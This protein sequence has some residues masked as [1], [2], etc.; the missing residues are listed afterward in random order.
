MSWF[1]K[2]MAN[3]GVDK[4]DDYGQQAI[5]REQSAK[6]E[7]ADYDTAWNYIKH[8][9]VSGFADYSNRNLNYRDI[10]FLGQFVGHAADAATQGI[11][12]L[13]QFTGAEGVGNYLNDAAKRGEERLPP[14]SKPELSWNYV[15]DPNGVTSAFGSVV[16]SMLPI[17]AAAY[18]APVGGVTAAAA[19]VGSKVPFIGGFLGQSLPHAIRWGLTG[20]VE[21]AMEAGGAERDMREQGMSNEEARQKA[22]DVFGNNALLLGITN[23]IGG[24]ALPH[25]FKGVTKAAQNG[26]RLAGAGRFA[27][28]TGTEAGINAL[29]EGEQQGIQNSVMGKPYSYNPANWSEDQKEAAEFGVAGTAPFALFG[30]PATIRGMRNSGSDPLRNDSLEQAQAIINQQNQAQAQPIDSEP[31]AQPAMSVQEAQSRMSAPTIS[32]ENSLDG[33]DNRY[34][35]KWES[36]PG[37][38]DLANVQQSVK[39]AFN[40]AIA[41]YGDGVTLTGGAE[42]GYH[43]TGAEGHEGGWKIDVDKASVKDPQKFLQAMARHGFKV[44]DEGDHYDLSGHAK[45]GVGGTVVATPDSFISDGGQSRGT[46]KREGHANA[47][48]I[49]DVFRNAGYSD[50]A[51]AGILG[52]A[53]QEHNFSTDMAEE[54]DVEGIG[55]VGGF[56]MFQWQMDP[57]YGGRGNAFMQWAQENN[58]DPNNATVQA[59]YA[60]I[61]AQQRGLTP[62]R[63]NQ[64]TAEEAADLWTDEWE[65]GK[66][67]NERQ[68][69]A[70]WRDR[71]KNGGSAGSSTDIDIPNTKIDTTAEDRQLADDNKVW[72]ELAQ[73][74][75][76]APFKSQKEL[77]QEAKDAA[78]EA[79]DM[80]EVQRIN[81]AERSG[82]KDE[83]AKIADKALKAKQKEVK[84]KPAPAT[85][86]IKMATPNLIKQVKDL[87]ASG[88]QQGAPINEA[89]VNNAL[90]RGQERELQDLVGI[91]QG[92]INAHGFEDRKAKGKELLDY[93]DNNG[94]DLT[95]SLRAG[96]V[97]G[98]P[99]AI[100][101]GQAVVN[102]ANA[103]P[104]Q[105][106]PVSQPT[107]SKQEQVQ[108]QPA[109]TPVQAQPAP[110]EQLTL[111]DRVNEVRG[112]EPGTP[113][114]NVKVSELASIINGAGSQQQAPSQESKQVEPIV[115]TFKQKAND[116]V[117]Q[118]RNN[119]INSAIQANNKIR[120]LRASMQQGQDANTRLA[121][122]EAQDSIIFGELREVSQGKSKHGKDYGVTET[123]PVETAPADEDYH[124]FFDNKKPGAVR[125]AKKRLEEK[126]NPFG[127]AEG[128]RTVKSI[129]ERWAE[130]DESNQ[131]NTK[132]R[133]YYVHGNKVSKAAYDYYNHMFKNGE[134]AV[135]AESAQKQESTKEQTAP[136]ASAEGNYSEL[137]KS[138][139][140]HWENIAKNA[141]PAMMK[142]YGD[143]AVERAEKEGVKIDEKLAEDAK[144]GNPEA[145]AYV[146]QLVWE[147]SMENFDKLPKVEP[148]SK[149]VDPAKAYDNLKQLYKDITHKKQLGSDWGSYALRK[150]VEQGYALSEDKNAIVSPEGKRYEL[151]GKAIE[152]FRLRQR[153]AED[154]ERANV[155]K[156]G[157]KSAQTSDG[158]MAWIESHPFKYDD[159]LS[160]EKNI[161]RAEKL[162][163]E[164]MDK[165]GSTDQINTPER[166]ELRS[167]IMNE[168]Y[169]KNIDK[170]QKGHEAFLIV[171][172]PASG[173]S[174][175]SDP[176]VEEKGAL[177][178]DSDE[179]KKRLPEFS[180][181]LLA[182]AV[183]NESDNIATALLRLAIA[184]GDNVVMPVVGRTYNGLE[185]KIHKF[186]EAGYTVKL[187]YVDLPMNKAIERVKNRFK[188]EGRLVSPDYLKSVG[189]NPRENYDKLKVTKEVDSYEA[190]NNDVPRGANPLSIESSSQSEDRQDS[191]G[192]GRRGNESRPIHGS[193][194]HGNSTAEAEVTDHSEQG[195]LSATSKP[196][197][198]NK[199]QR[200]RRGREELEAIAK[201]YENGEISQSEA[202]SQVTKIAKE[203]ATVPKEG[204][205]NATFIDGKM[206]QELTDYGDRLIDEAFEANEKSAAS[207]SKFK[208]IS[209]ILSKYEKGEKN[210]IPIE[211]L[212]KQVHSLKTLSKEQMQALDERAAKIA[213][214]NKNSGRIFKDTKTAD[215][216]ML[217]GLGLNDEAFDDI[218]VK[219]VT[220]IDDEID[221]LTKELTRELSKLNANPVFN[222]R[223]YTVGLKLAI[224]L[225]KKGYNNVKKL[226]AELNARFGKD[227]EPWSESIIE[228]VRTWPKGVPFDERQVMVVSQA[229]GARYEDGITS[230]DDVQADMKKKLKKHHAR[231]APMIEASYNGISKFFESRKEGVS[232][233]TDSGRTGDESKRSERTETVPSGTERGAESVS[234]RERGSEGTDRGLETS[235]AE[236]GQEVSENGNPE[237][238]RAGVSGET[239]RQSNA[240]E[241]RADGHVGR[242]SGSESESSPM[243]RGGRQSSR[244]GSSGSSR[245]GGVREETSS[246]L[247]N[248]E[249][250]HIDDMNA[251]FGGTPKVR[252]ARN[253]KAIEV[254]QDLQATKRVPT[255]EEKDAMAAYTG[256]GSFGQQLFQGTYENPKPAKGWEE[257]SEWLRDTLGKED[258]ESA[259]DSI[260]NA[261]YT[262]PVIVKAMWDMAR[263]MGFKNGRVLEPSM[264]VGNFFGLMP[265][266]MEQGSSLFGVEMDNT[267]GGM[268]KM[269]YP[270]ANI[271]IKPYQD[272]HVADGTYD[273]IVGNVPFGDIAPADRRYDKFRPN[274]HDYFFLKGIDELRSGGIMMAITSKGTMDKMNRGV[275]MEL[276]KKAELV[277]AYRFPTGAFGEYAG[278]DVVTDVLI[279]KKR[280][281]PIMDVSGEDWIGTTEHKSDK[282]DYNNH[283]YYTYRV[284]NFFENHPEKVLGTMGFGRSTGKRPG[285][286]VTMNPET[287][288]KQ[289]D[290][291]VKHVAKDAYEEAHY[292]KNLQ[293]VSNNEN[294][295]IGT[296][297]EVDGKLYVATGVDSKPIEAFKEWSLGG[298][299]TSTKTINE[300]LEE[301]KDLVKLRKAYAKLED[302]EKND[303]PDMDKLRK[304]LKAVYDA[305]VAKYCTDKNG[306]PQT[307]TYTDYDENGN[308]VKKK[309]PKLLEDT[310]GLKLFKKADEPNYFS[311]CAL[312]RKDGK[313]AKILTERVMRTSKKDIENPTLQE[314]L[315]IQRNQSMRIDI[316]EIAKMAKKSKEEVISGLREYL[317]KTPNGDYQVKDQYLSGNVRRKLREAQNAYANGDKDMK[318]NIEALQKVMPEDIPYYNISVSFGGT[319]IDLPYYKQFI[320]E[321]V[322][323]NNTDKIDITRDKSGSWRVRFEDSSL[324]G[325]AGATTTYGTPDV[326]FDRLL[327]HALNH[328][329]PTINRTD[330]DGTRYKDE[331]AIE[332][333]VEQMDKIRETFADWVWQEE[334]RK[335]AL[336]HN[337]NEIMNNTARPTY[338]GSFLDM[339]GMMLTKGDKEFNLRKHQIN[340]I[341]RGLVNGSGI[342]AHE[343]GT[344][345]TYT[346]GGLAME[347]RR[348]G[349][350]KKPLILAHNANSQTVANDI[351]AMY[352]GAK[353]LYIAG[354]TKNVKKDLMRVKM[355]DWDVIV[356]PHSKTNLLT[357][358]TETLDAM[359]ADIIAELEDD[360]M[361]A[362]KA[363][364]VD[365]S[366]YDLDDEKDI[367]KIRSQTAKDLVKQR[368]RI[369]EQIRKYAFKASDK[370]AIPFEDLGIDMIIVDESHDYKKPPFSTKMSVKGLQKGVSGASV[371]L[372]FLTQYVQGLNNGKG[373][374]LFTG[375]PITNTITEM[376]H[377]MRYVMPN[378]M[379]EAGVYNFDDWFNAF[380]N[381][382]SNMEYTST[383]EV[384]NVDRLNAFV[385]VA[386]LRRMVGQYMD[387]VFAEDMPEFKPRE[388]ASGKTL[389]DKDL[390]AEERDYLI[391]GRDENAVG[392]P[393]MQTIN[394][395]IPM[396]DA[397]KSILSMFMGYAKDWK[398]A[399]K[400]QRKQIMLESLPQSPLYTESSTHKAAMDARMFNP[401][402]NV[403]GMDSKE[404]R[405][406]KNVV[407]VYKKDKRATQVI[408]MDQGKSDSS[409]QIP[410]D[411]RGYPIAKKDAEGRTIK[412][413]VQTYNLQKGIID[414]LIK[415]GIPEKEIA[416]VTGT[417]SPDKKAEIANAVKH[418]EIRVVIGST[419]TLGTGVNMQDNLKAIH[420]IDAPWMPGDLE[421]RNGRILR[422]G[423]K[424][425]TV[426]EYRYITE[427]LDGR[428]WQVLST[429]KKFIKMFMKA[430]DDLRVLDGDA[431]DVSSEEEASGGDFE[432]TLSKATGDPRFLRKANLEETVKKLEKSRAAFVAGIEDAKF[433]LQKLKEGGLDELKNNVRALTAIQ[434]KY[435]K[436]KQTHADSFE[437][438][439]DG[440]RYTKTT[441]ANEA[442][443]AAFRNSDKIGKEFKLGEYA[444]L[445]LY[446][447]K[448]RNTDFTASYTNRI[449][450][451][452]SDKT[453]PGFDCADSTGG[454]NQK[455]A[456]VGGAIDREQNKLDMAES[457]IKTLEK[458]IKG[459]FPREAVLNAKQK[460]LEA[461]KQDLIDNPVPPPQWLVEGAPMQA[462]VIVDGKRGTVES[463]RVVGE[464]TFEQNEDGEVQQM[465]ATDEEHSSFYVGV[466]L[467]GSDTVRLYPWQKVMDNQGLPMITAPEGVS[468]SEDLK[469]NEVRPAETK[470]TKETKAEEPAKEEKTEAPKEE[471]KKAPSK[472]GTSYELVND[473]EKLMEDASAANNPAVQEYKAKIESILSDWKSKKISKSHAEVQMK[474]I[475]G[476]ANRDYW[477]KKLSNDEKLAVQGYASN[478]YGLL[479]GKA[480]FSMT[481]EMKRALNNAKVVDESDY[482][483]QERKVAEFGNTIGTP[484]V[485]I[486][487]APKMHGFHVFTDMVIDGKVIPAGSTVLN[488][489]SNMPLSQVFWHETFHW[490]ANNKDNKNFYDEVMDYFKGKISKAQKDAFVKRNGRT[491]LTTDEDI[492]EEMLADAFEDVSQRVEIFKEMGAEQP[493]LARKFVAWVKRIMDKFAEF[494]HNPEG[495]LTTAQRDSFVKAF[496]RLAR[497]MNDGNG[498]PLF[499]VYNDGKEIRLTNGRL[500]TEGIKLSAEKDIDNGAKVGDN[501]GKIESVKVNNRLSLRQDGH[502][503]VKLLK[504]R[505]N[506]GVESSNDRVKRR[507]EEIEDMDRLLQLG[508]NPDAYAELLS[509][510]TLDQI[511]E[512][513]NR[514]GWNYVRLAQEYE[515]KYNGFF[516]K[517]SPK[518]TEENVIGA[519]MNL[520]GAIRYARQHG[521]ISR[522]NRYAIGRNS[523]DGRKLPE[524][525]AGN[526]AGTE[527]GRTE[528]V[529]TKHS[530]KSA[531]S[532][533]KASYGG[534]T[535]YSYGPSDNSNESL[536]HR[537]KNIMAGKGNEDSEKFRYRKH[538]TEMIEKALDVK[539]RYGKMEGNKSQVVYKPE[540]RVLRSRH[541]FDWE[542]I[543]PVAG[544]I[545]AE[546][547]GIEPTESMN[548]YIADW[549]LTGA[550]NN[551][552]K[553]AD[554]FHKAMRQHPADSA[555]LED[556]RDAF[557]EWLGKDY[558]EQMQGTIQWRNKQKPTMQERKNKLYEEFVEELEPI[559][560][561]VKQVNANLTEKGQKKLGI[562]A[563]PMVAFRMLRG[564]YGRAMAALEGRNEGAVDALKH[565]FPNVDFTG[566]KTLYQILK[567]IDAFQ[568]AEKQ[569]DFVTYCTAC[570]IMDMHQHNDDIRQEQQHLKNKIEKLGTSKEDEKKKEEYEADIEKLSNELMPIPAAYSK[571]NCQKYINDGYDKY[572]AAQQDL[573][574]FS[575]TT[576]A[577]LADS[578]V[579]SEKRF[580]ELLTKWQNYVPLF[581]VFE[582]NED[583]N[584]GD[585]MKH[586][587]GS[588]RDIVNPLE[589]IIRNTAQFIQKAELNKAKCLLADVARCDASGWL[590]EEVDK[591][592]SDK[593]T[594][595]FWENGKRKYLQTDP[596]IVRAVNNMGVTN[597]DAFIK[598]IHLI[599]RIARACFTMASPEFAL[600]NVARD[601]QDATLYTKYG[602]WVNPLDIIRG[603]LHAWR[604]D[605]VYYEWLTQGAAQASALSLDRDY[606]QSTLDKMGRGYWKR[607]A[608][609]DFFRALID[610]LQVAGEYSEYGTRIAMYKKTKAAIL[611]DK[612]N[613]TAQELQEAMLEAAFES[614]DLMDFARHG[615]AGASWNK[616]A[617]FSNASIQG[618]DK[619]YR[620]LDF[621]NDPKRATRTAAK[622]VLYGALPAMMIFAMYHDDDWYKDAPNWLKE[623]HWLFK[624]GDTTIRIPKAADMGIRFISNAVEK[625]LDEAYNKHPHKT[626]EY[627]LPIWDAL[628]G[629]MPTVI[630]PMGENIANYSFFTDRP[631]VPQSQEKLPAKLQY[632]PY[633]TSFAKW[634]GEKF[635][636]APSKVEHFIAGHTGTL[637]MALPKAYDLVSGKNQQ[638]LSLEE[639]P[640]I[641][642]YLYPQFKSPQSV[643]DYYEKLNEQTKL[644]NEYKLTHKRPEGFDPALLQ[645]LENAQK[646]LRKIS[647]QEKSI[648]DNQKWSIHDKEVM[649]RNIQKKRIEIAKRALGTK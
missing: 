504:P 415:Q 376:Y 239:G 368:L 507:R 113:V 290:D 580:Q 65:V 363:D 593:T 535:K 310:A 223:V 42:K 44:G 159:S 70:E 47:W 222:P 462:D 225:T 560:R 637:G 549:I 119:K 429:K 183:H 476:E 647:K 122:S 164:Y 107:V 189:L 224:L 48:A 14:M 245:V 317:F 276:A 482:T 568:N 156:S 629:L 25:I 544:R 364:G 306:K 598:V 601:W 375:T 249:N 503:D 89:L 608:S 452:D 488:R 139:R 525:G 282:Y 460:E 498:R 529:T 171:G 395:V 644:K 199:L 347:S 19:N 59:Q 494:F 527:T 23:G 619:L 214:K 184:S 43:A 614:R 612:P 135:Q 383:G 24:A 406:I 74:G 198:E 323:T 268:A 564:S 649:Q 626:Q 341:Y 471:A 158:H 453:I 12:D 449:R 349:V 466:K 267:T 328:T 155:D 227:I 526:R 303:S 111:Q 448:Q 477:D 226:V 174:T 109:Q 118:Y 68:Y 358:K 582:D 76:E 583:I 286:M 296:L 264:G 49:Y 177:L 175:I 192:M 382:T 434:D 420:H 87:A 250:Y 371:Q 80:D 254:F 435:G 182:T 292:D 219:G 595:T 508:N 216:E 279:F 173:K 360:A 436:Y 170:R 178:V 523:S 77:V 172:L 440:K 485:W 217:E 247:T 20:P 251:L 510:R 521:N 615:K 194:G 61:E 573:V 190:W 401:N 430:D 11:A 623:T 288:Q 180:N 129:M 520:K 142:M 344:G 387:I 3:A 17:G 392:R 586:I 545:A 261:H 56:G 386:E 393:Y 81:S 71:I 439:I 450:I 447:I 275:R 437:I 547:L 320:A 22:W 301:L 627:F 278:T 464:T 231:F 639:M 622:L 57:E 146:S 270:Q 208:E 445:N 138:E 209:D 166:Q 202:Y 5:E 591:S 150:A 350:A 404:A 88:K 541:A 91:L 73:N 327:T 238:V 589:S 230:L 421:Q 58:L 340:A 179:A 84:G 257:E 94:I 356:M 537:I 461:L 339:A 635:D 559:N 143:S 351:Q 66:R 124:G 201:K 605:D 400:K 451:T 97:K 205:P 228:T 134:K 186:K 556:L 576:A 414:G 39:N 302:A 578:G 554:T 506:I 154:N 470:E 551:V 215:E 280:E 284:N 621:N 85:P 258:W 114:S 197:Q 425:N 237:G 505:P 388:T 152:E 334:K 13:A 293:Y 54:K 407:D 542:N 432:E 398:K 51:I 536:F 162:A 101:A 338:D 137:K 569:R 313:P 235:T 384:D 185:E 517:Y 248:A 200:M 253:R 191:S 474:E 163:K 625:G 244:E 9:D 243:G 469:D 46:G 27:G 413:E 500:V 308:K 123:Q 16:G 188:E 34:V 348:F 300:R 496:G 645:R 491:D 620:S 412:E 385:N 353:V 75:I 52:R 481:G 574:H 277:D 2:A 428:R 307:V 394:E 366:K 405:V 642:G 548:N 221:N 45:G 524:L 32:A 566:F 399:N 390:T 534:E 446:G 641:R 603:F 117:Y 456:K 263:R 29:E 266:D 381:V 232:N 98:Y 570:H 475:M 438:T 489:R 105:N 528:Q 79:G 502:F 335:V 321:L 144:A 480:K 206:K 295:R 597:T 457:D 465:T 557:A 147:H 287:F 624:F 262:A 4:R 550:P 372:S 424:W 103:Q 369:K 558:R 459:T 330:P 617:A 411:D 609:K 127:D 265:K 311:L 102:K 273:L 86:E 316:D 274:L 374:H 444:G 259:K 128:F 562:T 519:L 604:H 346:M 499:K 596:D 305:H 252:F 633:T 555:K 352:P 643:S 50:E 314:A 116:I 631:I 357:L 486:E 312:Q 15:T 55:R 240:P 220:N 210:L 93:A 332:K 168:L 585:S 484:V 463:Y 78:I 62:E 427:K 493:S 540:D 543:L 133:S 153:D 299:I 355:D 36:K 38:T 90:E 242:E 187:I 458:Q 483:S 497:D 125:E 567:S 318:H 203:L 260:I 616:W 362:A 297:Q 606:T 60:L 26:S 478:A 640:L 632:G 100:E 367:K 322:G 136:P 294:D 345:K 577:M 379:K 233:E 112:N 82:N 511:E 319:W 473:N 157:D 518:V 63:M 538:L 561:M 512:Y 255:Q 141:S 377:N 513:R 329:K 584:F 285:L 409:V 590:L 7:Q 96:L 442:I 361:E 370:E 115:E 426:L 552:S 572:H 416:V 454:I 176:L 600:R 64:L 131:S 28:A 271:Q 594:I 33:F 479:K 21:A 37:A 443:A 333:A 418:G 41:E 431:V 256:W 389:A 634:V 467:D 83:L 30:L 211:D 18:L 628:P 181:G 487:A 325:T 148:K 342:Y 602:M 196:K 246:P 110:N 533:G 354:D 151:S 126:I 326:K 396:N 579:I 149:E 343:V 472:K 402:I 587:K 31:T 646:Q 289:L 648:I 433:R 8:G 95:P 607:L 69:A 160:V 169:N 207:K 495:K 241:G 397:Q 410:R 291:M 618:W 455:L 423:N 553:E 281:E 515:R 337:Y 638:S 106:T 630:L 331:A 492:I 140:E 571:D 365:L 613:A 67:G 167:K 269:L 10:P 403:S 145:I 531:F 236:N 530:E 99:K 592:D 378:E 6:Q 610:G 532:N 234:E 132:G 611:K 581:R 72:D 419:A 516:A 35:S 272:V 546:Q 563:D 599:T 193:N 315:M 565:A 514:M 108:P 408:M 92:V 359:A 104:Q 391:N 490:I 422:Q 380:A 53:Q 165:F 373:V 229:I 1:D 468:E 324:N 501:E 120:K 195:G 309:R 40:A 522:R 130:T 304:Q 121:L 161:E 336:A 204:V 417:T 441:D 213:E 575:N 218:D 298:N 588:T 539:L 212:M 509:D 636:V 283:E